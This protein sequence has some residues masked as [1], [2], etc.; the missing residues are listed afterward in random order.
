MR[1]L[2]APIDS[3]QQMKEGNKIS[4]EF[5]FPAIG[6]ALRDGESLGCFCRRSGQALVLD[7]RKHRG[8]GNCSCLPCVLCIAM[9]ELPRVGE[10][11][12]LVLGGTAVL[13]CW[14]QELKLVR[15]VFAPCLSRRREHIAEPAICLLLR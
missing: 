1:T 8:D 14:L 15:N 3:F 7:V 12:A 11:C 13:C 6:A 2:G 5:F 10:R 9:V 4:I